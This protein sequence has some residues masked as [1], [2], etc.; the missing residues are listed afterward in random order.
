MSLQQLDETFQACVS[1]VQRARCDEPRRSGGFKAARR[2]R[3]ALRAVSCG[4]APLGHCSKP[5][6]SMDIKVHVQS[7]QGLSNIRGEGSSSCRLAAGGWSPSSAASALQPPRLPLIH[8]RVSSRFVSHDK[9]K[10]KEAECMGLCMDMEDGVMAWGG[11]CGF[12]HNEGVRK[13]RS[14]QSLQQVLATRQGTS[15]GG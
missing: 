3:A 13:T 7:A 15:K 10:K 11:S 8:S 6:R 4:D 2:V 14:S 12:N 5:L 1:I 9:T